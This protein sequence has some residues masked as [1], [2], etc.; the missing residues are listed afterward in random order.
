MGRAVMFCVVGAIVA[1]GG[2]ALGTDPALFVWMFVSGGLGA[3]AAIDI[4]RWC[5]LRRKR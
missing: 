3:V 5:L 2:R 1:F 4:S